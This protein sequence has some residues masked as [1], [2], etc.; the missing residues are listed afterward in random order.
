MMVNWGQYGFYSEHRKR[1]YFLLHTEF[2]LLMFT[3][4]CS[5]LLHLLTLSINRSI[6][7]YLCGDFHTVAMETTETNAHIT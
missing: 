7:S 1:L 6:E 4:D 2:I 5:I 3:K